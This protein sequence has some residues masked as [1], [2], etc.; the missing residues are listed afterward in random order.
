M[1]TAIK[2]KRKNYIDVAKLIGVMLVVY[3]HVGVAY[4]P[5]K[6]MIASFHMPL[7]FIVYGVVASGRSVTGMKGWKDFI[8]KKIRTLL[9]PYILWCCIYA[10]TLSKS[11]VW[12]NIFYGSNKS[13]GVA[14]TNQVLWFLPVMFLACVIYQII[15]NVENRFCNRWINRIVWAVSLILCLAIGVARNGFALPQGHFLAMMS[16]WLV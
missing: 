14:G 11:S 7:F 12:L 3:N 8:L 16:R 13:L 15:I 4:L 2:K 1:E 10:G 6:R 9:V 5:L